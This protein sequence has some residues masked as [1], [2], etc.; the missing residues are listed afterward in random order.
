MTIFDGRAI[1]VTGASS[2]IGRALCLEL[3]AQRARLVLAARD[4]GKL[5]EVARLCRSR[6]AD[7]LVV[8]TDVASEEDCRGLV[9]RSA[10][11]YG[12]ID[13][14]V[15]NA[16]RTMWA[17]LDEMKDLS[18]YLRLM[19]V[20]YMGS[21]SP[22]PD[23]P[24][25]GTRN[26]ARS[27]RPPPPP[28]PEPRRRPPTGTGRPWPGWDARRPPVVRRCLREGRSPRSCSGRAHRRSL[29]RSRG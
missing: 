15:N 6:G 13:V 26:D 17:R 23:E 11:A 8:R 24:H 10:D 18:L 2:G 12:G 29:R 27:P 20:N 14:L 4:L 16:G 9:A 1:V 25:S 7:A 3:A 21:V 19:Q 22:V 5:E 28:T